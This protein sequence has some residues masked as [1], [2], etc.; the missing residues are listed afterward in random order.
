MNR[1]KMLSNMQLAPGTN[2]T[3]LL[4]SDQS[5]NSLPSKFQSDLNS[6]MTRMREVLFYHVIPASIESLLLEDGESI[7]TLYYKDI[8]VSRGP[9]LNDPFIMMSGSKIL[10]ERRDLMLA[11]GKIRFFNVDRVLFPPRGSLY[12]VISTSPSLTLF[13]RLLDQTSMRSELALSGPFTVFAPS[14]DAFNRMD[15][16]T[17]DFITRDERN[18]KEFLMRHIIQSPPEPLLF[19]SAIPERNSILIHNR[20]GDN[21]NVVRT[22]ADLVEID[23]ARISFAD[24]LA[25]NGVLHVVEDILFNI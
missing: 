22:A 13:S 25:T 23:D 18:A 9:V 15:S 2:F 16:E 20:M 8:R 21:M 19:T 3:V 12:S 10:N 24:I 7:P 17:L 11:N 6:N 4:P 5:I 1:A 14:N